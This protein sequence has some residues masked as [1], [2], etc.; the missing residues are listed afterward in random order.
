MYKIIIVTV[1]KIKTRYLTEGI[2]DYLKRTA[3]YAKVVINKVNDEHIPESASEAD[4]KAA[5]ELEAKRLEKFIA[6]DAFVI[7]CDLDGV[8]KTSEQFAETFA[9]QALY[10]K[11]KFCFLIGGSY[12]LTERLKKRSQLRLSFGRMTYPHQLMRLILVEQIYRA[13]K[14]NNGEPYHK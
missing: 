14:I 7:A 13:M 1:G 8:Q 10:G 2:N 4:I 6:D 12:G 9:K 11:S 3:P 5:L